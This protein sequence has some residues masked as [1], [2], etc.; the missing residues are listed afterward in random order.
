VNLYFG[1]GTDMP[2]W[3]FASVTNNETQQVTI[4][5]PDGQGGRQ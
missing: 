1:V 3:G 5:T 4:V 2:A